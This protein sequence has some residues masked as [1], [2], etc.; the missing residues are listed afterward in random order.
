M[1]WRPKDSIYCLY[2]EF[3]FREAMLAAA[4]C[5]MNV[6]GPACLELL[7]AELT[8]VCVAFFRGLNLFMRRNGQRGLLFDVHCLGFSWVHLHVRILA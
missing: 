6:A 4:G 8:F 3:F 7:S 2:L 5:S 1:L